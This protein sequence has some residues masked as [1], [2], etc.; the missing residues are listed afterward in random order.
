M[1]CPISKWLDSSASIK[2]FF[3]KE[4]AAICFTSYGRCGTITILDISSVSHFIL[5]IVLCFTW[6]I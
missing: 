1:V 4:F 6:C 3:P 2:F 5:F